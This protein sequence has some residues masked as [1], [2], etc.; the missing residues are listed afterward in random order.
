MS[1]HIKG[2][3]IWYI[4]D[5]A[6]SDQNL[7]RI[8][9]SIL[10]HEESAQYN[11]FVFEK[12][13]HQY[14]V[15]RA[16][17]K[18][19]L[20]LYSP[21]VSSEK[22]EFSKNQYGK[23]AIISELNPMRLEFNI[24]HT[25]NFITIAINKAKSIGID[26]E[27]IQVE[28]FNM[29]IVDNFF[30]PIE[31]QQL[32]SLAENQRPYRFYDLWTLKEAYIKACGKGLSIPLDQFSFD[33]S[34]EGAITFSR[35]SNSNQPKAEWCFYQMDIDK[36]YKTSIAVEGDAPNQIAL[37][38]LIPFKKYLNRECDIKINSIFTQEI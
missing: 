7:L 22:W 32:K 35:H 23:P 29:D 14:L 28:R 19:I 16:A 13:K 11:R 27:V 4:R 12:H 2:V 20:S 37:F 17:L 8:Y 9:H 34:D 33:I 25:E 38:E 21:E 18:Y 30:S 31:I 5:Q 24:S 36:N 1:L 15:T 26:T 6:L 10:S 3:H